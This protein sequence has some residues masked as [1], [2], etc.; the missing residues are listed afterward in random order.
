MLF[1]VR[2]LGFERSRRFWL[3]GSAFSLGA[4]E[5]WEDSAKGIEHVDAGGQE[6]SGLPRAAGDQEE[7][8]DA[9]DP[10]GEESVQRVPCRINEFMHVLMPKCGNS[11]DRR[12]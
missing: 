3:K 4:T 1:R 7:R 10:A 11:L 6:A 12:S 2:G 5:P 8:D 9:E